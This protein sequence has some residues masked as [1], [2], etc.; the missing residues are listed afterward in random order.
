MA[1]ALYIAGT[2]VGIDSQTAPTGGYGTIRVASLDWGT[3]DEE[4]FYDA[5]PLMDGVV[6]RGAVSKSRTVRLSL[7]LEPT[8]YSKGQT[9]WDAVQTLFRSAT[10][11][12][13][14]YDRTNPA[15]GTISRELLARCVGKPGYADVRGGGAGT[16]G[17]RPNG[18]A[19]FNCELVAPFP[20]FREYT[21]T[22]T[23]LTTTG[24][25]P[26]ATPTVTRGGR[27]TCGLRLHISSTGTLNSV[28]VS[29][30]SRSMT[31]T[32][33]FGS[34]PGIVDWY[35]TDPTATSTSGLTLSIPA[36]LSLHS[37][38]TTLTV[39]PGGG[40]SGTHTVQ[41]KHKALWETV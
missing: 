4:A 34:T 25:T 36:H 22:T 15:G 29:D 8:S 20:W 3:P 7:F 40:S 13:L 10:P 1:D 27:L 35:Y 28:T 6:F 26:V 24:T 31:L 37:A 21:E 16:P 17:L 11:I 12:S 33:T 38:T 39:T 5:R 18:N 19:F 14:R 9:S 32:G 41:V 2:Q 30:G 23:T